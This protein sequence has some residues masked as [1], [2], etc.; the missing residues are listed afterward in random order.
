MASTPRS[1]WADSNS[2]TTPVTCG[3]AMLVPLIVW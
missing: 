3:V 2:A 1:G